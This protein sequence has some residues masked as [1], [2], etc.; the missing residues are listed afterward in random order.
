M[1][2]SLEYRP[3]V[4]RARFAKAGVVLSASFNVFLAGTLLAQA[5]AFGGPLEAAPDGPA[6]TVV[7]L[8]MCCSGLGVIGSLFLSATFFLLWFHRATHNARARGH[9][10]TFSP[11]E[12]VGMWFVPFVN[13]VRPYQ[14]MGELD[15]ATANDDRDDAVLH[16]AGDVGLWWGLWVVGGLL[17]WT[18]QLEALGVLG[19]AIGLCAAA[20]TRVACA[21]VVLRIVDRITRRLEGESIPTQF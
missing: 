18:G 3:L 16:T 20:A 21:V 5:L 17:G 9:D 12:A 19:N 7:A 6:K 1:E 11:G 15:R 2:I 10:L 14:M 13:L 4:G 8:S